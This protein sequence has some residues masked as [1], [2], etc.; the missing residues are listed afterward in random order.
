MLTLGRERALRARLADLARL[1][2]GDAVLDVGCGTGSLAIAARQRVGATGTVHGVDASPEMLARARQKAARA[3][4]DV[5]FETA[6]AEALPFPDARFD[7]VLST[8]LLHHLPKATRARLAAEIRRVLKPGGRVLA[9]DFEPP[10]RGRRGLISHLHRHGHAPLREIV[11]LLNAADLRVTETG[12]VGVSDLQFALAH[13]PAQGTDAPRDRSAPVHRQLDPLPLPRWLLPAAGGAL[14]A[15]HALVLRAASS[16]LALSAV[17]AVVA[18][19]VIAVAHVGRRGGAHGMSRRHG[20]RTGRTGASG[21]DYRILRVPAAAQVHGRPSLGVPRPASGS[22]SER[23]ER[24]DASCPAV[25]LPGAL[26]SGARSSRGHIGHTSEGGVVKESYTPR[27]YLCLTGGRAT[28]RCR[29]PRR[30]SD[31][32]SERDTWKH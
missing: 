24:L 11:E 17:A 5:S 7:V 6:S 10:A 14:V 12:A 3:G 4:A 26:R 20:R 21:P 2:P 8:L 22:G 13:A 32:P 15:A 31:H 19:G 30:V 27:G 18:T 1:E 16:T 29:Y 28:F 25:G 9:V 23:S